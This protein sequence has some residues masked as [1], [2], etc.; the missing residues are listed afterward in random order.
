MTMQAIKALRSGIFMSQAK[1]ADLPCSTVEAVYS[2]QTDNSCLNEQIGA[3]FPA[4]IYWEA[5]IQ[6]STINQ[7]AASTSA[8]F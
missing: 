8:L 5:H 3:L 2:G 6:P 4:E 1:A 7:I